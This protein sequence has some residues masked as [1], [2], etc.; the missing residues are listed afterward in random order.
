MSTF[1][2]ARRMAK[3]TLLAAVF[4]ASGT[5]VAFA[6]D[7]TS[8]DGG[9][10]SGNQ[11]DV[12]VSIPISV[13]G[14]AVALLGDALGVCTADMPASGAATGPEYTSGDNS[15]LS[16]NQINVPVSVPV[17]V[18]GNAIAALGRASAHCH[19]SSRVT[20]S[21]VGSGDGGYGSDSD[22]G[23]LGSPADAGGPG[24]GN[25]TG[26][27]HRPCDNGHSS[28]GQPADNDGVPG[29][30]THHGHTPGA[31]GHGHTPGS[32]SHHGTPA[33]TTPHGHQLQQGLGA[34]AALTSGPVSGGLPTTGTNLEALLAL[35]GAAI[36]LGAGALAVTGR[37]RVLRRHRAGS[38]R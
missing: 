4:A 11:V 9:V 38:L 21:A 23:D 10:L 34:P 26:G 14:N 8:G 1:A 25:M 7:T 31:P 28:S 18:C 29:G 13:C 22:H 16:G 19:G 17:A 30:T 12:P 32:T 6:G 33:S 35:A 5:G 20:G 36:A 24:G 15:L 27:G 3:I 2:W 37:G